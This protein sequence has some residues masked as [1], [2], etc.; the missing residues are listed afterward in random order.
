M[1][2]SSRA[3]SV[4]V[5]VV[6]ALLVGLG[7]VPPAPPTTIPMREVRVPAAHE[8]G[9]RCLV[10]VLP[11]L[12]NDPEHLREL[13]FADAIHDANVAADVTIAEAHFGYYA[14]HSIVDRLDEDLV[15]PALERG[16]SK[17]WL[18]G[19]SLG[20]LGALAYGAAHADRIAGIILVSPYIGRGEVLD[21]VRARGGARAWR[22]A[23]ADELERERENGNGPFW[24]ADDASF[25]RAV[26]SF[27]AEPRR[28]DGT[29]VPIYVGY[30]R[31]DFL[32][33]DQRVLAQSIP[34]ERLLLAYGGHR[35]EVFRDLLR[36]FAKSGFL[37]RSCGRA[38]SAAHADRS[39]GTPGP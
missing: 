27:V 1:V 4:R 33:R 38:S 17:V 32:E 12:N 28:T 5:M 25:Y 3:L 11:G 37:G 22:D 9:E 8:G 29:E 21:E 39:A 26:W 14:E 30:G 34:R 19:I 23:H 24:H 6:A 18:V 2:V 7:C 15:A 10:V 36:A 20:A 35:F 16:Y 31:Y 13:G